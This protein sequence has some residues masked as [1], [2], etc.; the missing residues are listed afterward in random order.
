MIYN[1]PT[2]VTK[3]VIKNNYIFYNRDRIIIILLI[4]INNKMNE[5]ID[6]NYINFILSIN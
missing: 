4:T 2:I 1:I 3:L 5:W 6:Y